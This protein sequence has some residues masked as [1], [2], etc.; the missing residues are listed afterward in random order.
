MREKVFYEPGC[1][2]N[3]LCVLGEVTNDA[4]TGRKLLLMCDCGKESV[5]F[6]TN[7]KRGHTK[8]C[9]CL[10]LEPGKNETHGKSKT[11][12]YKCW[13]DM[14]YRITNPKGEHFEKYSNLSGGLEE[15]WENNFLAFYEHIGPQPEDKTVRWS[16]G[17][18]DND[19]GYVRGNVRWEDGYL[20]NRNRGKTKA[21][22]SGETGVTWRPPYD[23][24][25][26]R[27]IATWY[28]LDGVQKS[29][30]FSEK[31]IGKEAAISL[32]ATYRKGVIDSLNQQGA[33]YSEKHGA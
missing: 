31:N 27:A 13:G 8:S 23:R 17:R 32:A 16:V 1:R 4:A 18:I 20:Q 21:N 6:I 14:K 30:G 22:T 5:A 15:A 9:G 25:F 10:A 28:D 29:K 12:E 7:L 2:F 11:K 26:G 24:P 19:V 3:K 33:G